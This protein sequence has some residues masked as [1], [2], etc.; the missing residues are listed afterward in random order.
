MIPGYIALELLY[1]QPSWFKKVRKVAQKDGKQRQ[2]FRPNKAIRFI[3]NYAKDRILEKLTEQ[4][5]TF[6]S[7][8]GYVKN[9]GIDK[10]LQRHVNQSGFFNQY[11]FT[12][13]LK[14]AYPSVNKAELAEMLLALFP[15]NP[16]PYPKD[17]E[18]WYLCEEF[19]KSFKGQYTGPKIIF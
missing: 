9:G 17:S 16:N 7:A 6:P 10:H 15:L 19:F 14:K 4:E 13:D 5:I 12:T 3:H 11:W 18:E 1:S 2:Q 8:T